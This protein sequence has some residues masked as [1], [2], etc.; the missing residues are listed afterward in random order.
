M[1]DSQIIKP[2]TAQE[3]A[4]SFIESGKEIREAYLLLGNAEKRL[5]A[6]FGD[7]THYGRFETVSRDIYWNKDAPLETVEKIMDQL[8][9][10]AWKRIIDKLQ[11]RSRMSSSRK[12]ELDKN[13]ENGDLP[14]LTV[15]NIYSLLEHYLQDAEEIQKEMV[16]EVFDF[17]RPRRDFYKT[18]DKFVVGKKV[19]LSGCTERKWSGGGYRVNYYRQDDLVSLDRV[20][21]ILDG[22]STPDAYDSPLTDMIAT[23]EFGAGQTD[24]FDFKCY[25]NG[26]LH[27]TFRRLDLVER[28]NSIAGGMNFRE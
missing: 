5:N 24:Y 11:V 22:A 21:H 15:E 7:Y 25:K 2:A 1:F 17:L 3:M 8:S 23:A 10:S 14:D 20:F 27:I 13:L 4:E 6:A 16:K 18:N 19:I 12:E 9:R 26:N 28:L